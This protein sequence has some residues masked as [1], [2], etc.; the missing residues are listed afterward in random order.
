M[1][2][3]ERVYALMADGIPR[4]VELIA[5]ELGLTDEYVRGI[6]GNL[7]RDGRVRSAPKTYIWTGAG[8]PRHYGVDSVEPTDAIVAQAKASRHVLQ[9]VWG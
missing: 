2:R 7:R 1:K 8:A 3:Y 9:G 5:R 4:S 6:L